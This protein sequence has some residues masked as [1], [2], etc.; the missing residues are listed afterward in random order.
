MYLFVNPY[1]YS[2]IEEGDPEEVQHLK[3]RF[4]IYKVLE[5]AD[6]R[7]GGRRASCSSRLRACRSKRSKIG[8]KLKRLRVTVSKQVT[9]Q[10][11]NLK[12]LL[13]TKC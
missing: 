8:A 11:S 13:G 9:R 7:R 1:S 4:L 6:R 12:L 5:E 3:A 2:R 10:I